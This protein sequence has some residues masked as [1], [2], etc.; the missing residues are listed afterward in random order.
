VP[1]TAAAPLGAAAGLVGWVSVLAA[2]M[3][4]KGLATSGALLTGAGASSFFLAL[5]GLNGL[6][7]TAGEYS[8]VLLSR[9]AAA[10]GLNGLGAPFWAAFS[11]GFELFIL[12]KIEALSDL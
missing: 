9:L 11:A 10:D 7:G 2:D 3:G 4:L 1:P 5:A 6:G 12:A 8:L